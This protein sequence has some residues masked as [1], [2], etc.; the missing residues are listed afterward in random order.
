[1]TDRPT[2][3]PSDRWKD[4]F[5]GKFHFQSYEL[6]GRI[7]D[8]KAGTEFVRIG[9]VSGEGNDPALEKPIIKGKC[10]LIG[11]VT[12]LWSD[13]SFCRSVGRISISSNEHYDKLFDCTSI[14]RFVRPSVSK[15]P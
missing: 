7:E 13:L 14:G 5:I 4:R 2:D 10:L 3:Q 9:E 11:S 15:K 1:M 6:G 8:A 12:C